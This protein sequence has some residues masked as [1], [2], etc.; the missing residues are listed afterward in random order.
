MTS[1]MHII[2]NRFGLNQSVAVRFATYRNGQRA[3]LLETLDGEPWSDATRAVDAP[4][5]AD[6]VAI[7]DYSEN[8]GMLALLI[9]SGVVDA[10]PLAS[11]PSGFVNL[12]V[13]R[14]TR[15]ALALAE[16]A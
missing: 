15:A 7:K 8:E 16:G 5:P 4:I 10:A 1:P 13:H 14:L 2:D 12:P 11:I 3:I 9:K 6:C